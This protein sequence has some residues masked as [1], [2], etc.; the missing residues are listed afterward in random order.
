[1]A[2]FQAIA[3]L[4]GLQRYGVKLGLK[5]IQRLLRTVGD[6]HRWFPSILVWRD[7]SALLKVN[8]TY[9]AWGA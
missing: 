5:N 8:K 7:S 9:T 4:Y 3:Y 1:M 6:P 2:Y